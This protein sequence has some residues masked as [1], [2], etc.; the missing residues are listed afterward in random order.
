[1]PLEDLFFSVGKERGSESGDT[2]GGSELRGVE[3]RKTVVGIYRIREETI[4]LKIM[5]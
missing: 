2:R 5:K 4:V 3:G 1:L